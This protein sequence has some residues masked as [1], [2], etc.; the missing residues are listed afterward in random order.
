[1]CRARSSCLVYTV[2]QHACLCAH[3]IPT[4]NENEEKCDESIPYAILIIIATITVDAI[5]VHGAREFEAKIASIISKSMS[6]INQCCC[7]RAY[8]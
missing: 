1:M 2:V 4:R 5:A 8:I 7:I 6:H 3:E